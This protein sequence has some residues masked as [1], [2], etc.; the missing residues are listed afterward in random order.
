[1][2]ALPL[3]LSMLL[4]P[5]APAAAQER[6]PRIKH[7]TVEEGLSQS[8]VYSIFQDSRGLIWIGT[9]DGLNKFDGYTFTFY[10]HDPFQPRTIASSVIRAIAEDRA[11]SLW[12][13]TFRGGVNRMDRRTGTFTPIRHDRNDPGSLAD[14]N[15]KGVLVDRRGTLWVG[16][17]ENG[18]DRLDN[19]ASLF[20][21]NG[22][23]TRKIAFRHYPKLLPGDPASRGNHV[24][25]LFEDRAGRIWVASWQGLACIEPERERIRRIDFVAPDTAGLF[26]EVYGIAEDADGTI[27]AST[28]GSVIGVDPESGR[29][30]HRIERRTAVIEVIQGHLLALG[31]DHGLII[32]D[33]LTGTEHDIRHAPPHRESLGSDNIITLFRDRA[34]SLWIGSDNGLDKIDR[35]PPRFAIF[36]QEIGVL[37][38]D[39]VR[40]VFDA[41][42]GRVLFGTTGSGVTLYD[43]TAGTVDHIRTAHPGSTWMVINTIARDRQGTI[44]LG[45]RGGLL[46][47]DVATRKLLP[48][49]I[50]PDASYRLFNTWAICE[51]RRGTFWV[52]TSTGLYQYDRRSGAIRRV[53]LAPPAVG[54]E[55][56]EAVW[57]I[58]EDRDGDLWMGTP[59]GILRRSAAT[60][61]STWYRHDPNDTAS[62]SHSEAFVIFE[63]SK[64]VIWIGTWGGGLN[65][66]DRKTERFRHYT[67]REG[68]ASN[69]IHGIE[70]DAAGALW[71]ST[72]A[73]IS[74]F[75]PAT[76]SFINFD[77][78]D[79]VQGVEFNPNSCCRLSTGEILFGGLNGVNCFRPEEIGIDSSRA[80]IVIT[81]F[82]KF[83]ALAATEL[84]DGESVELSPGENYCSFEFAAL[85][86]TNSDRV[87]Y[88]YRLEG[89]DND[90]NYSGRRRYAAY[91]NLDPGEYVF[92]VKATNGDGVWN[93]RGIAIRVHV[94]PPFWRTWMFRALVL[95]TLVTAAIIA[96]RRREAKR[97]K[98]ELALEEAR[99]NERREIAAELH[100][101]P[102]QDLYSTRFMI[103]PLSRSATDQSTLAA[104]TTIDDTLRRVRG[105]L[106]NVCGDLQLPY[107]DSGLDAAIEAHVEHYRKA[108]PDTEIVLDLMRD[109][110][111]LSDIA[112]Q[113]LFRIYRSAMNNIAKH[114]EASR[115]VIRLGWDR[116]QLLLEVTDNGL[117]FT[118]PASLTDLMRHKHYGLLL[119]DAH[120]RAM[121]GRLEV[122]S[123]PGSGTAVSVRL[124]R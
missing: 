25:R 56:Y 18:V 85:V 13:G 20:G 17:Q 123:I 65:R 26:H 100:D 84:F 114:A 3:M 86:Y 2:L 34:G 95:L 59:G 96:L 67:V 116:R 52:G 108:L 93:D 91:T 22:L 36:N 62:I 61:R 70:E 49:P 117:G 23:P 104:I 46:P 8:F 79:G 109:E 43:R 29:V 44:W 69:T 35:S 118:P 31:T 90:W 107:L 32:I 53:P 40:S 81:S 87:S 68:L 122:T 14:D 39:N 77:K 7:L 98:L 78:G 58:K 38:E 82:K 105:S 121:G 47:F 41:G 71:I 33:P 80:P 1:M 83:D 97:R 10:R 19:V 50:S 94:I 103:E 88:A 57:T 111:V 54:G 120:A 45:T 106:R 6:A 113:N 76:E 92:R 28:G 51:D 63:D 89:F 60:G 75:T 24:T 72:G 73:G 15:I 12:V 9:R 99:E 42:N 5:S 21:S 124:E 115:V 74:K 55:S 101:G 11:G 112:R 30:I 119:A 64:G 16:T 37:D 48:L 4:W 110:A 102:L 27:W 66:F